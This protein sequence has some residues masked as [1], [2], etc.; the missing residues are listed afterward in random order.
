MRK[1]VFLI[2][3]CLYSISTYSQSNNIEIINEIK[4]GD[5]L[6]RIL[7]PYQVEQN[8]IVLIASQEKIDFD[9][10]NLKIGKKYT[11]ILN[12]DSVLISFH[13]Q[14]TST[15]VYSIIFTDPLKYTS[16][17]ITIKEV[18]IENFNDDCNTLEYLC[19]NIIRKGI[20]VSFYN[21][22]EKMASLSCEYRYN[23]WMPKYV[24]YYYKNGKSKSKELYLGCAGEPGPYTTW[25]E[26]GNLKYKGEGDGDIYADEWYEN[27]QIKKV[28]EIKDGDGLG[29]ECVTKELFY[30]KNGN[31]KSEF[32]CEDCDPEGVWNDCPQK[33]CYS[34]TGDRI[35]CH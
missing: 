34:A 25:W 5:L 29:Y 11:L 19:D 10:N 3:T 4:P 15:E 35:K 27:G 33:K 18:K 2:L 24:T 21:T 17:G 1:I 23:K 22:G 12:R 16:E 26:N 6:F 31:L 13:Y 30:Y 32:I 14:A 8:N 20:G 28:V 7:M 9:F